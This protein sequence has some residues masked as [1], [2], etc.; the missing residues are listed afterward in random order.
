MIPTENQPTEYRG[1]P[2]EVGAKLFV[3]SLG[4]T[5]QEAA[6]N[7]ATDQQLVGMF[8]G[9]LAGFTGLLAANF[10]KDLTLDMLRKTADRL[11]QSA[12]Q[13]NGRPN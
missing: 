3:D 7:G 2:A 9:I 11:E 4:P 8:G 6:N 10:G 1:T 13:I 5:L 12:E